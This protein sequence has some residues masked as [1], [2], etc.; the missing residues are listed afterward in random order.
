MGCGVRK[1]KIRSI[2]LVYFSP[3]RT[4]KQI[5]E[6]IAKGIPG[7]SIRHLDLTP[8]KAKR[9]EVRELQEELAIIGAPVYGGRLPRDAVSRLQRL[10][11]KDTP[12][13]VV[14][15]YGNR[16]Y[17]DALVELRDLAVEAGF[18]PVAGGAFIGEHSYHTDETPIARGRPDAKDLK[19][20][21]DFG[22]KI[23]E[24][25][26]N[27]G[28]PKDIPPLQVPGTYPYRERGHRA[29]AIAPVTYEEPCIKC[30]T[31]A[32]VCPSAAI[33]IGTLVMTEQDLCMLCCACVKNCPTGARI[34]EHPRIKKIA[35]WLSANCRERKE[36]E[37]FI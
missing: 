4:S 20:A 24:K 32:A 34:M 29:E 16:A 21:R 13:V 8:P 33:T 30:G 11:A 9:Q 12:A 6:G 17:E 23:R 25:M 15:V 35:N 36:A 31:C 37:T 27:L 3:T 22:Q 18:K 26:R 7:G 5:V 19:N 14:V 28:R 1:T 2:T 10:K